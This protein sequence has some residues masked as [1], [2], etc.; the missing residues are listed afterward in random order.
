MARW[1]YPVLG[2]R[3]ASERSAVGEDK[4]RFRRVEVRIPGRL[5]PVGT[6][7]DPRAGGPSL[8]VTIVNIG[9]EGAF[10]Q[11]DTILPQGTHV[12]VGFGLPEMNSS[13]S[14]EGVV[15]WVSRQGEGGGVGIHFTRIS[16]DE[17]EVV[18]RYTLLKHAESRG[19][20]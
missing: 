12:L 18:Y 14:A 1:P 20:I 19:L 15:R 8:K 9:P 13:V 11:T 17:K 16:K 4:R 7:D 6:A 10:C 5:E 3:M 2:V